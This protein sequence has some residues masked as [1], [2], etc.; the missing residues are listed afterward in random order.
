MTLMG[1]CIMPATDPRDW[2]VQRKAQGTKQ[3]QQGLTC[4]AY[5]ANFGLAVAFTA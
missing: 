2:R 5:F 4:R 1:A 3:A